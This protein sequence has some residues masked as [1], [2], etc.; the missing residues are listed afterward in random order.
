MAH[1]IFSADAVLAIYWFK[2][3]LRILIDTIKQERRRRLTYRLGAVYITGSLLRKHTSFYIFSSS[4]Y[5]VGSKVFRC[6]S[7]L[8]SK[9]ASQLKVRLEMF[10]GMIISARVSRCK[11]V[12]HPTD[13]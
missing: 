2:S 9:G 11:D 4:I 8:P 12:G 7:R 10:Y 6:K 5:R 1:Y 3:D 13:I